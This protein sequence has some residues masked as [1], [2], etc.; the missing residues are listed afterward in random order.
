ME[1]LKTDSN[2]KVIAKYNKVELLII[3]DLGSAR[4]TEWAKERLDAVQL[5]IANR[6][7]ER[8]AR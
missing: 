7:K 4:A 2:N 5:E 1:K 8:D 6:R 3:D